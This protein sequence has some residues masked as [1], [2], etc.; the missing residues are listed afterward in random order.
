MAGMNI[1]R[2]PAGTPTGGQFAEGPKQPAGLTLT[3]DGEEDPRVIEF[4]DSL[5]DDD[6]RLAQIL[7][8]SYDFDGYGKTNHLQALEAMEFAGDDL[9]YARNVGSALAAHYDYNASFDLDYVPEEGYTGWEVSAQLGGSSRVS[10]YYG[11]SEISDQPADADGVDAVLGYAREIDAA[12]KRVMAERDRLR[13]TVAK[14]RWMVWADDLRQ[15][16]ESV[17]FTGPLDDTGEDEDSRQPA[18]RGKVR[19]GSW[20]RGGNRLD[21]API[22]EDH[23]K[24]TMAGGQDHFIPLTRFAE[25]IEKNQVGWPGNPAGE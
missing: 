16:G 24:V 4:L 3:G 7:L 6:R 13:P 12:M 1:N 20:S 23:V 21:D 15:S 5:D 11:L 2:Q 19:Q 8:N 18:G 14:A 10:H 25:M 17:Y 9:D 22:H